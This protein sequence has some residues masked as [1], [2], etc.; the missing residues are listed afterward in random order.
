DPS[1][2]VLRSVQGGVRVDEDATCDLFAVIDRDGFERRRI[3]RLARRQVE[4]RA[5]QPAFDGAVLDVSFG[6]GH[7]TMGA[8]VVDGMDR[9]VG[10]A[11]DADLELADLDAHGAAGGHLVGGRHVD[12]GHSTLRDSSSSMRALS[13][14]SISGTWIFWITSLKNPRTTS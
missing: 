13:T 14:S 8:Q 4:L 6:Q 2:S 11:S 7:L 10:V 1:S 12:H 5:V 9:S 3:H